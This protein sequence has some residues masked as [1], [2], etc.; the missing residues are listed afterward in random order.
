MATIEVVSPFT[1]KLDPPA[2]VEGAEAR[3]TPDAPVTDTYV[4]PVAG[5]YEDVPEPVATHWYTLAHLEGYEAPEPSD[6]VTGQVKVMEPVPETP[7]METARKAR[8]E[9]SRLAREEKI[10][11]ERQARSE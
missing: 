7:E 8:Q 1:V 4:F 11:R 6:A 3:V 5:T 10:L 2:P 9:E